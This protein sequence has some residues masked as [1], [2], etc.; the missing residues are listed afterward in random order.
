[1]ST[2]EQAGN[3]ADTSI[4]GSV[5]ADRYEIVEAISEGGMGRV[6]RAIQRTLDREV[7]VKCIHPHLMTSESVVQRFHEEARV[8]S[9]LTHPGI[10]EIYDFGRASPEQ[11]GHFYIVMELLSGTDLSKELE[12][13]PLELERTVD[14]L[15]QVLAA[16]TEAHDKGVTHR[17]VKPENIFLL[18]GSGRRERV[19]L[20]DFGIAKTAGGRRLTQVGTLIGSPHYMSPEQVRGEAAE[21][22]A[23][24]YA[25]GSILFEAL[26]GQ[27]LFDDTE[28]MT[29]LQRQLTAPR[30]DPREV[31]PHRDIPGPL[32][33]L[34]LRAI[35]LDPS[36]RLASAEEFAR[37]LESAWRAASSSEVIERNSGVHP[38]VPD[39][40]DSRLTPSLAPVHSERELQSRRSTLTP[41]DSPGGGGVGRRSSGTTPDMRY[42]VVQR[43][44][45]FTG[46]SRLEQRAATALAKGDTD[47]ALK[48][49]TLGLV[50]ARALAKEGEVELASAAYGTFG[51]RAAS[52]LRQRARFADARAVLDEVL[53]CS[54][55][56][57]AARASALAQ[58]AKVHAEETGAEPWSTPPVRS[59]APEAAPVPSQ[60]P[61]PSESGLS[62]RPRAPDDGSDRAPRSVHRGGTPGAV[63]DVVVAPTKTGRR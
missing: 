56:S 14:L 35:A 12:R 26:T 48:H 31:A 21:V 59:S 37:A 1:M 7:A 22:S 2:S 30:P 57:E 43:A 36:K 15:L 20:I 17:D 49:L 60:A 42:R 10:V 9:R 34:C 24:L 4:V 29:I 19:K 53:A 55:L 16:L 13:G 44:T 58:L 33:E 3:S 38:M 39:D 63:V 28:L 50:Q 32:A 46:L 5:L 51:R 41:S 61:S 25:V 27:V 23:D 47:A 62:R 18:G 8:A 11:G 54:A 45:S 40:R 6:Y 52:L